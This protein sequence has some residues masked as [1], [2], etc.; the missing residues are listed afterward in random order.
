MP[1]DWDVLRR[2]M[3]EA[4]GADGQVSAWPEFLSWRE[5]L[6]AVARH[7]F[8]PDTVWVEHSDPPPTLVALHREQD[9]QRWL[10]MVYAAAEA[11]IT[12]VDNG[13]PEWG[14]KGG[15]V[16]TSSAS[17]PVVV[18]VMLAALDAQPGHRVCEVGTGTGYNAALLAHRL[19]AAQ[20]TSVEIDPDLADA[21]RAALA[22]AG[23][24][25][26]GVVT[27]DGALGHPPGAPY[28]R[29]I[30]TAACNQ[31]PY[32]WVQQ[33]VPGGRVVLPWS[34]TYTGALVSL[35]VAGD[36]TAGGTVV[37]ESSF[38]SL[39]AQHEL[40]GTVAAVVGDDEHRADQSTTTLHPYWVT[41]PHGARIAI[42]QRVPHC[43]WRY[44]PWDDD[45]IGVL[46]LLDTRSRSWAKLTHTSPDASDEQF[47][48]LQFG[49]R[50]LWDEVRAAHEW[51]IDAGSPAADRWRFTVTPSGQHIALD[52]GSAQI[53]WMPTG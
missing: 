15:S 47:P 31:I 52:P 10:Q 20:V 21:A 2:R 49:P 50:R 37:G 12:Q 25:G 4:V 6:G 26:V 42:G 45:R 11:V 1:A 5:A 33:T 44:W 13:Q 3:V 48:V 38:M 24:G 29:L 43:Q 51:W 34:S 8:I 39:R 19:G 40:R 28:D 53:W 14:E 9:P 35:T 17:C 23:F 46:W 41:G 27:G 30:A 16:P 22:D 32:S 18:A 7:E 36:G